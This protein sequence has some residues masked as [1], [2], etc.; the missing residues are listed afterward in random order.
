[1]FF[2]ALIIFLS[3]FYVIINTI[4]PPH[5]I[6]NHEIPCKYNHDCPTIL[7]YISICPYHYCEFWRTY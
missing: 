7:D 6:T 5:H 2:Y 3:S 4:D 1:M